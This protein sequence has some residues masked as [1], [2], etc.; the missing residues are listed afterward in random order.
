[1]GS[2]VL[3]SVLVLATVVVTPIARSRSDTPAPSAAAD[4]CTTASL[5]G[6][7]GYVRSGARIDPQAP[8]AAIGVATYDGAGHV[9]TREI[10]RSGTSLV[11]G[12][13]QPLADNQDWESAQP[14]A[15]EYAVH[16][17]CT[18][19][20]YATPPVPQ[21]PASAAGQPPARTIAG[22]GVILNGGKDV[23]LMSRGGG[24]ILVTEG[25]F[26]R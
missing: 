16:A 11:T 22:D 23:R 5:S 18:F 8:A 20:V 25:H 26:I 7:Y 17:D 3:A 14:V 21:G 2:K 24:Q 1:M 9:T 13:Q 19:T 6:L 4:T 12:R 10:G 15:L